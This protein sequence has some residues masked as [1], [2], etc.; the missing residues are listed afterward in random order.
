MSLVGILLFI[1]IL[2]LIGFVVHLITTK[3]PMDDTIKQLIIV[4]VVVA[5]VLYLI[6][7]ISGNAELP[8][9][10]GLR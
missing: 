3:I 4:V 8:N 5:V 1:L 10:K 9:F 7:L 2:A 6:A